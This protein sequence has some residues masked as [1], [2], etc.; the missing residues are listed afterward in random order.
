MTELKLSKKLFNDIYFPY[1][2]DY[3]KKFEIYYGGSGSGKS[4]FIAQKLIVKAL[5]RKRRVLII[6]KT[7]A[8]QKE[9]CWRL[10]TQILSD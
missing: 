2:F 4:V 9:S 7:M 1:L 6:R 10:I 3:S 5:N 8:S